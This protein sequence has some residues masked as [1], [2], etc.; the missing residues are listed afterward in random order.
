M[1]WEW[2]DEGK[3]SILQARRQVALPPLTSNTSTIHEFHDEQHTGIW[4]MT[5]A[6]RRQNFHVI[7][8]LILVSISQ[9]LGLRYPH[10]RLLPNDHWCPH[11]PQCATHRWA[12]PPSAH[13]KRSLTANTRTP[14]SAVPDATSPNPLEPEPKR[15]E[16]LFA[17]QTMSDEIGL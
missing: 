15:A 2:C 7:S 12:T 13:Y 14:A 17:V 8:S 16:L 1:G 5:S 6:P 11:E 9:P 10:V 3:P 4:H